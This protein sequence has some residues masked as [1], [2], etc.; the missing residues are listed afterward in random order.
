MG[1]PPLADNPSCSAFSPCSRRHGGRGR[2]QPA[3][4][5]PSPLCVLSIFRATAPPLRTLLVRDHS[6]LQKRLPS[7]PRTRR[8]PS[9]GDRPRMR[10][11]AR[12]LSSATRS[13]GPPRRARSLFELL[14]AP[15]RAPG[16]SGEPASSLF[17]TGGAAGRVTTQEAQVPL[18]LPPRRDDVAGHGLR[19]RA[20]V[21]GW[22]REQFRPEARS[23][24]FPTPKTAASLACRAFRY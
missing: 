9:R 23:F 4:C 14:R 2:G 21:E 13:P 18:G 12:P 20:H 7:P 15:S 19:R 10:Y 11:F 8:R 22:H 5:V 17:R 1:V 16:C 24:P 6:T 3:G